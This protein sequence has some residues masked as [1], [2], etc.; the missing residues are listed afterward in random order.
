MARAIERGLLIGD[1]L[2]GGEE[3][4]GFGR[5]IERRVGEQRIGQRLEARFARDLRFGAAL[6]LV[7]RVEVFQL[8][9][10]AG[11]R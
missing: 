8:D 9:L 3:L 10:G 2:V 5:G 1:A 6:R 4:G 11:A 7:G